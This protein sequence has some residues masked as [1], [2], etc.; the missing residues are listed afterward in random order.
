[1]NHQQQRVEVVQSARQWIA[2][3][4]KWGGN[5]PF[6]F[7]CSGFVRWCLRH[8]DH[9]KKRKDFD[10]D[11]CAGY[12]ARTYFKDCEIFVEDINPGD[13]LFYGESLKTINHVM[14]VNWVYQ[15]KP[16]AYGVIGARGGDSTTLT[17]E[18]ALAKGAGVSSYIRPY[19]TNRLKVIVNPW[20]KV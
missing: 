3:P 8:A 18:D 19:W 12:M 1:M 4:Y 14:M 6:Y 17:L 9:F 20:K 10:Q 7:D 16:L 11:M 5:G 2:S 15:R 13:L